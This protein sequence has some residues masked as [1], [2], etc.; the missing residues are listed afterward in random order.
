MNFTELFPELTPRPTNHTINQ[1]SQFNNQS[2]C[3]T[4]SYTPN[5]PGRIHNLL[6]NGPTSSATNYYTIAH[7]CNSTVLPNS[8]Y[9]YNPNIS[10]PDLNVMYASPITPLEPGFNRPKSGKFQ[11]SGPNHRNLISLSTSQSTNSHLKLYYQNARSIRGKI[12]NFIIGA[13]TSDNYIIVISEI[14]L[15]ETI[16]ESELGLHGFNIY[17]CDRDYAN[18]NQS[19]GGGV[20]IAVR[21]NIKFCIV[22]SNNNHKYES[23]FIKIWLCEKPI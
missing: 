8:T 5:L 13:L 6:N 2:A 11:R 9:Q 20:L 7:A 10:N 15:P 21:K 23:L 18:C 3:S 4:F 19:R 12:K 14:W 17:R 16:L 1:L 22:D